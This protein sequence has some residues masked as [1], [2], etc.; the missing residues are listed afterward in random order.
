MSPRTTV[1]IPVRNGAR[2]L[3]QALVSV[4][5]QIED[6]DE[7]L[8]VD[9]ASTDETPELLADIADPRL[10]VLIGSGRG[11]SAARNLGL[12]RA[13]GAFVAFL[14]HDDLWPAGR[15]RRMTAALSRDTALD[16][17]FGRVRTR[18]EPGAK[19]APADA[20]LDGRHICELVGS[21][22][23][24]PALLRRIAGFA[25]DMS[26]GEDTDFH[27]RLTEAGMRFRLCEADA[28]V[29]RR[30]DANA[31]NDRVRAR[32]G[33]LEVMRRKVARAR[34]RGDREAKAI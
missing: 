21:A 10:R 14:D 33:L 34:A 15:H 12:A 9:D 4:L 1:V 11:V 32:Q 19:V 13:Q 18:F 7:V 5:E 30:H 25:E 27:L 29:Y 8:A 17:V 22:L 23:F 2:Y 6:G 24:R 16:A 20:P 26:M 3:V 28:L 31:T